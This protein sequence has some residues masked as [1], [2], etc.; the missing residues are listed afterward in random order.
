ME[1]NY[2]I[3]ID[4]LIQAIYKEKE[5]FIEVV[6]GDIKLFLFIPLDN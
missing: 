6:M 5:I 2:E 1:N 4:A 3:L